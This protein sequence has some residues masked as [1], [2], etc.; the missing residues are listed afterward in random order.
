MNITDLVERCLK[1]SIEK[2]GKD[3]SL[4]KMCKTLLF[5]SDNCIFFI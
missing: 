4:V 2:S 5:S 1:D 3:D